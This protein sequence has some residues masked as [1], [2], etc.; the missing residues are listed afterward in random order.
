M[1]K[2]TFDEHDQ[3][4]QSQQ[5]AAG[6]IFNIYVMSELKSVDANLSRDNVVQI[7]HSVKQVLKS[8]GSNHSASPTGTGQ[9]APSF[10]ATPSYQP[11][12]ANPQPQDPSWQQLQQVAQQHGDPWLPTQTQGWNGYDLTGLWVSMIN[13]GGQ[14]NLRQSGPYLTV[15]ASAFGIPNGFGEG[16]INPA[17]WFVSIIGQ[18]AMGM[19]IEVQA[20]FYSDWTLQGQQCSIDPFS[21]MMMSAPFAFRKAF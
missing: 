6:D 5:N 21:G 10:Q 12:Y 17:T 7:I 1:D 2:P 9:Q 3:Q 19:P 13:P 14:I 20:Q 11:Q 16:V 8:D 18:N 15:V 4:V